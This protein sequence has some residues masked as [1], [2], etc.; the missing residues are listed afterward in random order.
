MSMDNLYARITEATDDMEWLEP[1]GQ[2]FAR[3]FDADDDWLSDS[4]QRFNPHHA[5][6]G[7]SEGGQFTSGNGGGGGTSSSDKPSSGKVGGKKKVEKISDFQKDGV[8]IGGG[9][10]ADDKLEEKFLQRW[11]DKISEAPADFKREFL[12]G[13]NGSM[14]LE[15]DESRDQISIDGVIKDEEDGSKIADYTR[16][17]N[18]KTNSAESSYFDVDRAYQHSKGGTNIGKTMLKANVEMYKK[19]GL[20]KVAV[21][22]NIDVGGYAWAKY[23]YVPNRTGSGNWNTLRNGL[24]ADLSD[25]GDRVSHR[26][27][28]SSY[29]PEEWESIDDD[30]QRRIE[31]AWMDAT[32]D[33]FIQSEQQNYQ[34]SGQALDDAKDSLANSFGSSD[35]WAVAAIK[36]WREGLDDE[37]KSIPFTN[38]QLLAAVTVDYKRDYEGRNDP[39][40]EIDDD[41]LPE[42]HPGQSTLPGIEEAPSLSD[43]T[44]SDIIDALTKGFNDQAESNAN[45]AEGPIDRSYIEERQGEYWDQ[46]DDRQKY[47]WASR[48]GEV[49][50]YPLEDD[51]DAEPSEPVSVDDAQRN[52][53]MR[54]A[55]SSDPKAIWAIADSPLGKELLLNTDWSGVLDLRDK[56]T[57]ARFDA[58]VNKGKTKDAEIAKG[59]VLSRQGQAA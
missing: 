18:F 24:I 21:H 59:I 49:P 30:D 20:D 54:L 15:Y 12:G 3:S 31:R 55:Q 35:D 6:A 45:E 9:T 22:A 34:E 52:A 41:S 5:P 25:R 37:G 40:I 1:G 58:Y 29:T 57:M 27:S 32:R 16:L 2:K 48:N 44:R 11:N 39:D 23:G 26:A 8:R 36:D 14:T 53:L 51:E 4:Q 33:E 43:E 46:M 56:D 13:L 19:L 17:I 47:M 28:G 50:E 7:S 42:R 38:E 10:R